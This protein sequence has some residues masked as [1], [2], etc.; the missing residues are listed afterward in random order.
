MKGINQYWEAMTQVASVVNDKNISI[1]K[2]KVFLN[3]LAEK[4]EDG[5]RAQQPSQ[6]RIETLKQV[7]RCKRICKFGVRAASDNQ[8]SG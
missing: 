1:D 2:K 8:S 7:E 6:I 5:L 4:Y 3:N